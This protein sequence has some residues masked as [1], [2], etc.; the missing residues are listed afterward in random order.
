MTRA[1]IT[2]IEVDENDRCTFYFEGSNEPFA[3]SEF[4]IGTLT[5]KALESI[6][7][8]IQDYN[9]EVELMEKGGE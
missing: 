7:Y 3:V 4:I 5:R 1:K 6:E 9:S 8:E 2:R